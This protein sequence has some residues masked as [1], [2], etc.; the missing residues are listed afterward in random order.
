MPS[1]TVEIR[2]ANNEFVFFHPRPDAEDHHDFY[3]IP[4]ERVQTAEQLLKWI[5][6]IAPK[7]WCDGKVIQNFIL[8]WSQIH[9]FSPYNP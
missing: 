1:D 5:N 8:V 7:T 9:N 2:V 3:W 4:G 6:Q